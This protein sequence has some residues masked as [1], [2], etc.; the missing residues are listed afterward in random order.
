MSIRLRVILVLTLI[1]ATVIIFGLGGGLYFILGHF[2]KTIENDMTGIAKIADRLVTAE[3]DL[4]KADAA[5]VA[6]NIRNTPDAQLQGSLAEQDAL[7]KHFIGL[8]VFDRQGIVAKTGRA[9]TSAE[10]IDSEV[11]QRAF[12]GETVIS[13]TRVGGGGALVLNVCAPLADGRVLSATVPGMFFSEVVGGCRVWETGS[14]IMLDAEGTVIASVRESAVKNRRNLTRKMENDRQTDERLFA[15]ARE[16]VKGRT[17]KGLFA[18]DGKERICVYLPVTGSKVGWTL[19]V[20]A[21]LAESPMRRV[22]IGLLIVGGVCLT[23]G[24]VVAIFASVIIERP[25]K[26]INELVARSEKNNELLYAVNDVAAVLLKIDTGSFT[27]DMWSCMNRVTRCADVDR[28][29]IWQNHE[30]EGEWYCS[31]LLEW[32]GGAEAQTG[33]QIVIDVPYRRSIPGWW[34]KL[35]AGVCINSPVN[36]LSPT[37][38]AQLLPQ[39]IVSLLVVPVFSQERFWGF[40]A[41]DDCRQARVF[42]GDEEKLLRSAGA[43]MV[44]AIL[45]NQATHDLIRAREDAVAAAEAKTDFLATISHEMRTPLNAIIG[46]SELALDEESGDA[47]ENLERINS[48]GMMLLGLVNDIL[49]ISKIEAGKLKL[50]PVAYD[51]PSLINDTVMLN[52]MRLG[53]KPITFNLDIDATLPAA[54]IGDELRVKQIF[55]NLLSNAFKYTENGRVDWRL[56]C[57]NDGENVWLISTVRDTG[58]GI[59][60]KDQGDIFTKYI[61]ADTKRNR[62]IEGTGLGLPIVKNMVEMMEGSIVVE[63][64]YGKGSAFTIR[65][66]QGLASDATLGADAVENLKNF[67]Y[68]RNK[69]DRHANMARAHLPYA[70]VLVVDDVSMNLV[71]ARGLM[72]AYGMQIDCVS[73]AAAA[74]DLIRAEKVKYHA[75]FMDHMM[76]G[77][78][79][80]E[81]TRI[82]RREIGTDYAKNIPIIVLTA[83]AIAGN[84]EMF[85]RSGFS[86]FLAKPIDIMQLDMVINRWVRDPELERELA[87]G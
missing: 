62:K 3:I 38:Q 25:Y 16:M 44:N 78:D 19:G 43:L 75:I 23:L 11:M 69:R 71:V 1:T 33:K 28:M 59:R 18:V 82:I 31:E 47:H 54:L 77:M 53:S 52:L 4:L 74:I 26:T 36:A 6:R 9:A 7:Y 41:F 68:S 61:Q 60:E 63:S 87:A 12:A 2:E 84:E 64:E 76:P 39:G 22:R 70:K 42:S 32:S 51:T 34:E 37:E 24:V 55:N 49:D 80:V 30:A 29:R 58:I 14:I 10:L 81:A 40:V 27:S 5:I 46:L 45:R 20:V 79:G 66:K 86:A 83:N 85:L 8:T 73:N 15:V 35:S 21:P 48:S 57:E 67:R 65:L 72:N 56:T 17:G 13:T 50:V